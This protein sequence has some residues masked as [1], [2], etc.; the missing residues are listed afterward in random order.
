MELL[1]K[2]FQKPMQKKQQNTLVGNMILTTDLQK[3][4]IKLKQTKTDL[5][6][7]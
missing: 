3:T 5:T 7:N 4:T 6:I 2:S 1:N